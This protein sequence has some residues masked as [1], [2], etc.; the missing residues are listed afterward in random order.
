MNEPVRCIA[1]DDEPPALE[2]VRKFCERRGGMEIDVFTDPERA[3]AEIRRTRPHIVFL[4]IEMDGIDGMTLASMV[5]Q[6]TCVI[7]TTAYLDYAAEGFNLDAVDYLHKPF[8]YTRFDTAVARALR[9]LDYSR[10]SAG[11]RSIVVKQDY[12]NV[13]IPLDDILYAEAMEAYSKIYRR[14]G[15]CTVSRVTL[16]NLGAMLPADAFVRIHRSYIV[17]LARI[18][19]YNSQEVRLAG[20]TVLP[21]GRQYASALNAAAGA[22]SL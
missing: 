3:L 14:S 22:R 10:S 9:R 2:V 19:S 13:T 11:A 20:G 8:S 21:V 7:F 6:G 17:P 1:V 16:K 4:D 12:N 5:P 18:A 15:G